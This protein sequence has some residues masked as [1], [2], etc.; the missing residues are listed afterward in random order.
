MENMIAI[1][2]DLFSQAD[3]S[4]GLRLEEVELSVEINAEGQLSLVGNGAKLG[5]SG[6]ITL[7]FS[8]PQ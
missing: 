3:T 5:N 2:N 1:V 6:G 4:T 7:K 8:R